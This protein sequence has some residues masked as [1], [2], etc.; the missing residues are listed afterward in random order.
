MYPRTEYID[1]CARIFYSLRNCAEGNKGTIYRAR[2]KQRRGTR[3]VVLSARI[4]IYI[5]YWCIVI[6][7]GGL[8]V[9]DRVKTHGDNDFY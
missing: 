8:T 6:A 5:V 7:G 1:R 3:V 4:F 2:C 9:L